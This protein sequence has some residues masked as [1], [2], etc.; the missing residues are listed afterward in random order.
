MIFI[1]HRTN[2]INKLKKLKKNF[3][4]EVD[5]RDHNKDIH[6]V[7]DPFKK[8]IR[9]SEYLKYYR[10]RF[11]ICNIKSERIELDVFRILKKF[12]IKKFFFL[13]SSFP[14]KVICLRRK[15]YNQSIRYSKFENL[16]KTNFFNKVKWIWFDTFDGLP[17]TQELKKLKKIGKK[18]CLV[19]PRLHQKKYSKSLIKKFI[20]LNHDYIDMIC[21]KKEFF[22]SWERSF[23]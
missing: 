7:H 18:I 16:P 17:K 22:K 15:I 12:K 20:N 9:F 13:D 4:V 23:K 2:S 10:H 1:A 6:I 5:L 19:C 14:M 3:G 11:I 21:T 8:G